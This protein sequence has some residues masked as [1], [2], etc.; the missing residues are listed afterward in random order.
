MVTIIEYNH[1]NVLKVFLKPKDL[2]QMISE[3]FA[4]RAIAAVKAKNVFTVVLSG[5]NTPKFFFDTLIQDKTLREE[6]PWKQIKFFFGDER[7]VPSESRESNYHMAYEHLFSKVPILENNIYAIPTDYH[8]PKDAAKDYESTLMKVF[9]L[10]KNEFPQFDLVYLGLGAD[11]HTASLMP[12][13]EAVETEN[14][15][16]VKSLW[17]KELNMYRITLTVPAINHAMNIVFLVSGLDKAAAVA[18]TLEGQF[19]PEKY[20]AQL[21]QCTNSKNIWYLDNAAA[22]ELSI[23]KFRNEF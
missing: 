3:D 11:A 6:I 21:I 23:F 20:P 13:S 9:G 2:F 4:H 12:F 7:Y 5:G 15:S 14:E 17:V 8:D 16:L 18:H 1:Y 22:S 19:L 10:K